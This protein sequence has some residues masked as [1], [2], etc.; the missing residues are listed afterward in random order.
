M[1][2]AS[3]V[4]L[5]VMLLVVGC[6]ATLDPAT[7][8]AIGKKPTDSWIATASA[9]ASPNIQAAECSHNTRISNQKFAWF[10]IDPSKVNQNG[11]TYGTCYASAMAPSENQLETNSGYDSFFWQNSGGQPGTGTGPIR[12]PNTGQPGYEDN[13]GKFHLGNA[14]GSGGGG[15]SSRN[16]D[17][18]PANGT[19]ATLAP[20]SGAKASGSTSGTSRST[21]GT[22][23][24]T[25]GTSGSTGTL[26]SGMGKHGSGASGTG[27]VS[28]GADQG[29]GTGGRGTEKHSP[30]TG[31]THSGVGGDIQSDQGS[32]RNKIKFV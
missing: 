16:A 10:K 20:G 26:G 17:A 23:G 9:K 22:S 14:P 4:A 24:F 2:K 8:N 27:K 5:S 7:G 30:G 21:D 31:V 1:I 12:D 11:S 18:E 13:S 32:T 28:S 25:G 19:S 3:V 15:S 29:A 6:S